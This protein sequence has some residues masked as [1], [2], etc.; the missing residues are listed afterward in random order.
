MIVF[1]GALIGLLFYLRVIQ[2]ATY[3]V[4]GALALAAAV[5][6]GSSPST[7]AP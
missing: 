2:W 4:G 3:L 7:A 5:S 6:A 1:L